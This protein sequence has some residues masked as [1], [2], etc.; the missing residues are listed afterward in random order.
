MRAVW[1]AGE[2]S[3]LGRNLIATSYDVLYTVYSI[4]SRVLSQFAS[5]QPKFYQCTLLIRIE[6]RDD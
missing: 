1:T 3:F 6:L 2:R 5:D 4:G